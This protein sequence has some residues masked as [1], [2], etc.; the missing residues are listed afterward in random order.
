M[1]GVFADECGVPNPNPNPKPKP[2]PHLGDECG[3]PNPNPDP[4]PKPNPHLGDECGVH[5]LQHDGAAVGVL[6]DR[7]GECGGSA[8]SG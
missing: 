2:N 3:V 6:L 5:A 7:E 4:K 1:C 8:W